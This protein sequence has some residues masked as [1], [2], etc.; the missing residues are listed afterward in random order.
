MNTKNI[1]EEQI[2]KHELPEPYPL[3]RELLAA[4]PYPVDALMRLQAPAEAIKDICQTP[5]AFGGQSLLAATA[6]ASQSFVVIEMPFGTK[7]LKPNSLYYVTVGVSGERKTQ[8][9]HEALT[10][11]RWYELKLRDNHE[12]ELDK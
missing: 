9:D 8:S 5:M 3:F 2:Q 6:L 10:A 12:L 4:Q 11:V 1:F 7:Q